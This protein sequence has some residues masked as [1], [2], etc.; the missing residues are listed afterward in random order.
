MLVAQVDAV[1]LFPLPIW[2]QVA[3]LPFGLTG[4]KR[5]STQA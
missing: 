3:A 5:G 4:L 2:F 1:A